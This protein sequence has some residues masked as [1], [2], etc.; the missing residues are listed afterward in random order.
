MAWRVFRK[1]MLLNG[2]QTDFTQAFATVYLKVMGF[3][4]SFLAFDPVIDY[5]TRSLWLEGSTH[6]IYIAYDCLG[7]NLY[8]IFLIFILAYPGSIKN[9]IR[10]ILSGFLIIFILNSM[11]MSA[12]AW[13]VSKWPEKM[14]FYHHFV[15]QGVIFAAIFAMWYLFSQL[16]RKENQPIP[17]E[18]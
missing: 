17:T 14:D 13:I 2:E 15:F 7:V 8:F 5:P 16:N 9:R 4:L 10:F 1:W 3:L 18:S 12:L 6:S 11:R